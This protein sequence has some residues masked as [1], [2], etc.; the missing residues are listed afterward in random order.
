MLWH[1]KPIT[2]IERCMGPHLFKQ[3]L[4][5]QFR[6]R[7][8]LS[9]LITG[10]CLNRVRKKK[11]E[12]GEKIQQGVEIKKEC[13]IKILQQISGT[14]KRSIMITTIPASMKEL[15][16]LLN[17][18]GLQLQQLASGQLVALW[19]PD[20]SQKETKAVNSVIIQDDRFLIMILNLLKV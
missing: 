19:L 2:F 1:S 7:D 20:T 17:L 11:E 13:T 5:Q 4:M 9:I 16:I 8:M 14:L 6:H 15:V 12:D 3:I 10:D 18:Y